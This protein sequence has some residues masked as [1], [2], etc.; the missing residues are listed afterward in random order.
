SATFGRTIWTVYAQD[1]W[2]ASDQLS[3]TAGVRVQF[4]EGDA[5][6]ENPNFINRFGF[7]NAVAFSDIDPVI[8]PR[9]G[10]T[11][12]LF[13]QGFFNDSVIKGGVGVFS[14]GDPIV[15]FSNAFSN[16]GF[17]F[18]DGDTFD[19]E[20]AGL[21]DMNGQFDV[22]VDGVFTGM[23]QCAIDAASNV[24]SQGGNAVQSTDP[25]FDNPTVLRA[26]LGF[27]TYL[28]GGN[29][30]F[31]NWRLDLD[32]IYSHFID[33]INWVDL[34][35]T[36][37]PALGLNGYTVDGRPIYR[38]IDASRAGCDA[39]LAGTGGTP[40]VWSNVTPACFTSSGARDDELQLTNGPSYDSHVASIILAKHFDGG[41]F[42]SGGGTDVGFGYAWMDSDNFRNANSS[43][44][45]SS[46]DEAAIFDRQN[47]SVGTSNYETK[48]RF[49]FTVNLREEFWDGYDTRVG[50]FFT[51]RSGRPYTLTFDGSGAFIDSAAGS[52]NNPLYIP[53]GLNDPNVSPMSDP[54]AVADLLDY[55]AGLE[56]AE[57]Y[58]GRT[59][60]SNTCTEDW[61]Y[62]LDLRISQEIPGFMQFFGGND[63]FELFADIDNV[64]NLLDSSWNTFRTIGQFGDGQLV[65]LV[66]GSFDSQGR[67]IITGFNPDDSPSVSV[68]S[69]VWKIQLGAR[70]KF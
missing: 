43:T 38:S 54:D 4:Y 53:S 14:G 16:N 35:Y 63:R 30:F 39:T 49:T 70:Y 61:V 31:D 68:S 3:L 6:R 50:L 46:Y 56:C 55:V 47:P 51:A 17:S 69:S 29:G 23:P 37:N 21:L 15:Y 25:N 48:H 7:S 59:I 32:Y 45:T 52:D 36:V 62:D 19:S 66:D 2:Q 1:E 44:A 20:C 27:T 42:T 5:P 28:G 8:L 41:L 22:V 58:S 24:A 9:F 60:D 10:F 18:A 67:Y 11:Y 33:P 34:A 13:D 57:G 65:D 40:P 26:N 12:D 64:L